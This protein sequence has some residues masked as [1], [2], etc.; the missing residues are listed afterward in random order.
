MKKG[1]TYAEVN[2]SSPN[3]GRLGGVLNFNNNCKSKP[4]PT[5]SLI[6][7]GSK[8]SAFTL[9]EVLI[10]LG[11]IGVVAAMTMPSVIK[12]YQKQRTVS[13]LKKAY[14]VLS[15]AIKMSTLE[16]GDFKYWDVN[17]YPNSKDYVE[18][19]FKPYLKTIKTCNIP[20]ECGYKASAYYS[21]WG[22]YNSTGTLTC[23]NNWFPNGKTALVLPDGIYIIFETIDSYG[24]AVT[25]PS[26]T[27][28]IDINGSKGP[29]AHGKDFFALEINEKGLFAGGYDLSENELKSNCSKD[30][31]KSRCAAKI[32]RDGWK[33]SDDY[34]W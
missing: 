17:N 15:Q 27:I 28:Y 10:T 24:N 30:G 16:N 3:Q 25:T 6:R 14:T 1:F 4:I 32:I 2:N 22:C 29:N 18:K 19:F 5:P 26:R 9:A 7:E 33:I 31:F 34:P 13:Q 23:T 12:H 20:D 21:V 8:K 11:V